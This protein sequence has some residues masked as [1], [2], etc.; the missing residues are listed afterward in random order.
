MTIFGFRPQ[1]IKLC[2]Q[3]WTNFQLT[4]FVAGHFLWRLPPDGANGRWVW[5]EPITIATTEGSVQFV[6]ICGFYEN[7]VSFIIMRNV[8]K[9]LLSLLRWENGNA[10][11]VLAFQLVY[12]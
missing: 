8:Y 9:Y 5:S 6:F 4:G 2:K 1:T 3:A 12:S 7:C 11:S 10:L